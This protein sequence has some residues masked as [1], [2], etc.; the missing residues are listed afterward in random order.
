[1]DFH[2]IAGL[3][4]EDVKKAHMADLS[5]QEQYGV[6]YHQF[7]LNQEA[8]TIFCLTEGPDMKTC[9]MV[10]RL[11]HGNVACAMTEVESGYYKVFMGEGHQVDHGIVR[12]EDGSMDLGYRSILVVTIQDLAKANGSGDLDKLQTPVKARK[13]VLQKIDQFNGRKVKW[14]TDDSLTGVFNDVT[15]AVRCARCIR[16]ELL[17]NNPKVVFRVGLSVGQPVTENGEFFT[18]ALTLAHRISNIALENQILISSL[19]GDLCNDDE[20]TDNDPFIRSLSSSEENFI[21]N[22]LKIT[23]DNLANET[24]TIEDLCHDI[25]VSRPQLY[26]KI[27]TLTGR[28]PNDLLRDLRMDKALTLLKRKTGNISEIA[29]EVGYKSPS[30]F[31]RCFAK[32]FGCTPSRFTAVVSH[33]GTTV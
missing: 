27:T 21:S 24:F 7:W 33:A 20:L 32:K 11:A 10:H 30:Y 31:A 2:K 26:R 18:N 13:L 22:L 29:L 17:A 23:E 5:V 12:N 28:S 16:N 9:E 25:G 3:T 19:A 14:V 8:G 15:Q 1:M 6:K 4:I